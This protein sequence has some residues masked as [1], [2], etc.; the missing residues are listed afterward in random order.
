MPTVGRSAHERIPEVGE[1]KGLDPDGIDDVAPSSF[2]GR[3]VGSLRSP[4]L[5][6]AKEDRML[7][8]TQGV[9][10]KCYQRCEPFPDAR[11]TEFDVGQH[12]RQEA[13]G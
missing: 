8:V 7:I 2:A 13:L 6:P 5:C 4:L 9:S 12:A 1:E 10:Q 3:R 11:P